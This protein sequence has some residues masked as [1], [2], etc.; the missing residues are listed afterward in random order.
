MFS[1]SDEL[2]EVVRNDAAGDEVSA[3]S[4]FG[5]TPF[6]GTERAYPEGKYTTAGDT[7]QYG[8]VNMRR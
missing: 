6:V 4:E 7:L 8:S 2:S 3:T 1:V 5:L